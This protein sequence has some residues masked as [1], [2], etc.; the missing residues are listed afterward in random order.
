MKNLFK[1]VS[2]DS[3]KLQQQ[4][5][6]CKIKQS[7]KLLCNKNKQVKR[8]N[9]NFRTT[10]K[11][12]L[13]H[14]FLMAPFCTFPIVLLQWL[15]ALLLLLGTLS[16]RPTYLSC[17]VQI[18]HCSQLNERLL[19]VDYLFRNWIFKNINFSLE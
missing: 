4:I 7:L 19:Y 12:L 18:N 15:Q 11:K 5:W 9:K 16:T 13:N 14:L 8:K 3:R 6:K 1:F 17:S 2:R 10:F